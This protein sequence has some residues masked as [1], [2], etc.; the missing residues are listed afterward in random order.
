MCLALSG[1]PAHA[2][3]KPAKP[4]PVASARHRCPRLGPASISARPPATH[5][6]RHKAITPGLPPPPPQVTPMVFYPFDLIRAAPRSADSSATIPNLAPGCS[7]QG[8]WSWVFS[9]SDRGFDPAG[10]GRYDDVTLLWTGHARGRIGYLYNQFL[11]FFSGG[12]AFA[13]TEAKHFVPAGNT[14]YFETRVLTGYTLGGGIEG[15]LTNNWIVRL[16]YLHDHFGNSGGFRLGGRQPL[17]DSGSH[18]RH[19]ADFLHFP[20]VEFQNSTIV[21]S[22]AVSIPTLPSCFSM[23]SLIC[24]RTTR[25]VP[26]SGSFSRKLDSERCARTT[27][28]NM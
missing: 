10:S 5:L 11:I 3:T 15:F 25:L 17:L 8:D 6:P 27:L 28:S 7:A 16:E 22:S 23:S 2:Q 18:A 14:L 13:G 26:I 12:A 1:L 4:A 19:G 20:A 24:V 21:P 9:A